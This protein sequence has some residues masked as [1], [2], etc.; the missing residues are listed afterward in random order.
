MYPYSQNDIAIVGVA[1]RFP[2]GANDPE[3]YWDLL[4]EGRSAWSEVPE[5]R[6]NWE[7]FYHP[8]PGEASIPATNHRGG[9]FLDV[10]IS[11]FDAGFFGISPQE[12]A[13]L[14]PQHRLQ[15]ETAYEAIENAGIPLEILKGSKTGVY[16]A[17]L[18]RDWDRMMWKDPSDISPYHV[19]GTGEALLSNRISYTFD[20]RGPSFTV[21]TGCS[22]SVVALHQACLSLRA[23]ETSTALVGGTNVIL[24]PDQMIPMS[25]MG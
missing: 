1:C 10:D 8:S 16:M 2:G 14:D 23:G 19:T 5:S 20:L 17:T 15:L 9:H 24:S 3:A 13:V 22:G 12:A 7:A 25:Y 18:F 4:A 6:F 11:K 21:D